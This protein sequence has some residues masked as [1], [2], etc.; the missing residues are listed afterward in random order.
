MEYGIQFLKA[1]LETICIETLVLFLLF[2]VVF[3]TKN[4]GNL[5]LL[6]TGV[7]ATFSTLP[8]LWF[9]APLF[10]RT[11]LWYIILSEVFAIVVESFIIWGLLRIKYTKAILVS[12]ICNMTSFL[13]GLIISHL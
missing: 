3:K 6:L 1:L 5:I 8:Y 7:I 4:T 10:I 9:I 13:I 12:V 11:K 2:K